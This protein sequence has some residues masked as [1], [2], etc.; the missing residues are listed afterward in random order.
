MIECRGR[1]GW[2]KLHRAH[3]DVYE[4]MDRAA[5]ALESKGKWHDVPPIYFYGPKAEIEVLL[6]DLL[7]KLRAVGGPSIYCD[8]CAHEHDWPHPLNHRVY[9]TCPLCNEGERMLNQNLGD[10]FKVRAIP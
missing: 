1:N 4:T 5:V 9:G 2:F 7:E 6:Q 8:D 10:S 3:V